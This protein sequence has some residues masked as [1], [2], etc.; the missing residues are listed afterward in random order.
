MLAVF[1]AAANYSSA[2]RILIAIQNL[3]YEFVAEN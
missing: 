2:N 3:R 1:S